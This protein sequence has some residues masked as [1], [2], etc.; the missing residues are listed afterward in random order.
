MHILNLDTQPLISIKNNFEQEE[1]ENE[2]CK[3]TMP[4]KAVIKIDDL[5]IET[6]N[7]TDAIKERKLVDFNLQQYSSLLKLKISLEEYKK[8][9]ETLLE[10]LSYGYNN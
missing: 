2:I 9:Y 6:E 7:M 1:M 10:L 3:N 8:R 5:L 4:R